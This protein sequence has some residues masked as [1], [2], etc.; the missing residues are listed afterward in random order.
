M[1]SVFTIS[2]T[3]PVSR[4]TMWAAWTDEN[5][6]KFWFGPKGGTITHVKM[7]LRVGGMTHYCM[8]YAETEMWGKAV[9]REIEVP[10]RLVWVNSFS[11]K[12]GGT[13][14]HPMSPNW[15][16]EMLTTVTFS[17]D[18][19][20]TKVTVKWEPINASADE[21]KTF[22]ENHTSMNEGWSGTFER[23]TDYLTNPAQSAA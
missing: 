19:N 13:T 17:D 3:F 5:R 8:N 2:Q 12:D 9:Y 20:G 21:Q 23:L 15:P 4:D 11:D 1:S 7:D 18:N 6:W 14:R 16:L 10:N 22:D